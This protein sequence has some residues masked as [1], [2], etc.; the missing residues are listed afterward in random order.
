MGGGGKS[1]ACIIALGGVVYFVGQK[2]QPTRAPIE[3]LALLGIARARQGCLVGLL[4]R[5]ARNPV[6]AHLASFIA[7]VRESASFPTAVP[8]VLIALR[9][10]HEY[11]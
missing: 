3:D 2:E 8:S 1:A 11:D 6:D 10:I 5:P 4:V 9:P 7:G